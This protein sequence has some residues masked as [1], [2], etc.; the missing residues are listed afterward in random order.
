[1]AGIRLCYAERVLQALNAAV[2]TPR[3]A[4]GNVDLGAAFELLDFLSG[5]GMRGLALFDAAGE[6]PALAVEERTRLLYLAVKRSRVPVLAGVGAP[7]LEV[8]LA[9]AREAHSA[10]AAAVLVPPPCLFPYPQEDIREF[11]TQFAAQAGTGIPILIASLPPS[12]APIEVETAADLLE[13]GLFAGVEYASRDW[14]ALQR[15]D[16]SMVWVADD[17][18]VARARCAGVHGVISPAACAVPELVRALD[19]AIAAADA[20]RVERLDAMLQEF[21]SWMQRFPLPIVLKTAAAVR[22][23]KGGPLPVPLSPARARS[24]AE[25]REWFQGWLPA[26]KKLCA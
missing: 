14:V 6:Y 16:P 23:L 22:G 3:D 2:I 24:L 18:I 4:E 10:G 21:V 17:S 8:S 5:A 12:A 20:G 26:V 9:L 19:A 11:Y 13:T 25:F 7:D 1:M 15:L